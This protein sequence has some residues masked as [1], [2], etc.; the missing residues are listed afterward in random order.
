MPTSQSADT[1][2]PPRRLL[3][4]WEIDASGGTDPLDTTA[5]LDSTGSGP[6]RRC[7]RVDAADGSFFLKEY[8]EPDR[9]RVLFRHAVTAALD[10][11]GLPVLA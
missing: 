2:P 11:E 9:R 8:A 10:E 5:P 7:W 1:E 4:R 6:G 3:R